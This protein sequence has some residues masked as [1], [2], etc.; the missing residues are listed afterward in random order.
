MDR[1][2]K[3][4]HC[5]PLVNQFAPFLRKYLSISTG[6]WDEIPADTPASIRDF[7]NIVNGQTYNSFSILSN[8]K[9]YDV[10]VSLRIEEY[11]PTEDSG[12]ITIFA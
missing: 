1:Y 11:V 8:Y 12:L 7:F 3:S 6:D 9:F 10:G 2:N 5:G 4:L